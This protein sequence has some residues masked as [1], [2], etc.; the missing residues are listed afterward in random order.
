M[1]PFQVLADILP[2]DSSND[3]SSWLFSLGVVGLS[4]DFNSNTLQVVDE[5]MEIMIKG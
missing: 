1:I 4:I 2:F 3:L 5:G